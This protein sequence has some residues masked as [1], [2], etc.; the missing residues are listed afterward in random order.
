MSITTWADLKAA[1]VSRKIGVI[2]IV[3]KE[4]LD[5]IWTDQGEFSANTQLLDSCDVADWNDQA[6]ASPEIVNTVNKKQ[7]AASLD[8]GKSGIGN[9]RATYQK[10]AGSTFDGTGADFRVWVYVYDK[11]ELRSEALAGPVGAKSLH[12]SIGQDFGNIYFREYGP[13]ELKDVVNDGSDGWNLL[14]GPLSGFLTFGS[15]NITILDSMSL[16]FETTFATETI[17][18]GNIKMDYWRLLQDPVNVY[19]TP[20]DTYHGSDIQDVEKGGTAM[21]RAA[22]VTTLQSTPLDEFFYDIG[23]ELLY[24]NIDIDNTPYDFKYVVNHLMYFSNDATFRLDI[25]T[26]IA[27]IRP[28]PAVDKIPKVKHTNKGT[29]FGL[30]LISDASFEINNL[31]GL[32]D[33]WYNRLEWTDADCD[34]YLGGE[35]LPWSEYQIIYAGRVARGKGKMS[36]SWSRDALKIK[37]Q[38][39]RAR[40]MGKFIT[41]NR[42][43]IPEGDRYTL[44]VDR[45]N[46]GKPAP[47]MYGRLAYRIPAI[48]QNRSYTLGSAISAIAIANLE[49]VGP[50]TG[51]ADQAVAYIGSEQIG[52][53]GVSGNFLLALSRGANDTTA[54]AHEAGTPVT[55]TVATT[56]PPGATNF[57][58]YDPPDGVP[59]AAASILDVYFEDIVHTNANSFINA[60]GFLEFRDGFNV[61]G[62]SFEDGQKL[63]IDVEN[64]GGDDYGSILKSLLNDLGI[65]DA[66]LDTSSFTDLDGKIFNSTPGL[67]FDWNDKTSE[68]I[69][70]ILQSAQAWFIIDADGKISVRHFSPV[71][72]ASELIDLGESEIQP[73]WAQR[74]DSKRIRT[75]IS[76]LYK[77][78]YALS[79]DKEWTSLTGANQFEGIIPP[80]EK[81]LELETAEYN[82]LYATELRDHLMALTLFKQERVEFGALPLENIDLRPGDRIRVNLDRPWGS[83]FRS[84]EIE[85]VEINIDKG[86]VDI[87]LDAHNIYGLDDRVGGWAPD[88]ANNWANATADEK[89]ENGFWADDNG[90]IDPTD[91]DTRNRKVWY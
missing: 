21:N 71:V 65:L 62:Q 72:D 37:I 54:Q 52:Y 35:D 82:D 16:F 41:N 7:G 63:S 51:I 68:A 77:R 14:G 34:I 73:E 83:V 60:A 64:T 69:Q 28:D 19:S 88:G 80:E 10:V 50:I 76:V 29:V 49:L 79:G 59:A 47:K 12:I 81:E 1:P 24:I 87:A 33:E 46:V 36:V 13:N 48:A 78:K 3:P 9:V 53:I 8:L 18:S 6:A 56:T 90:F 86:G 38:D 31:N 20:L 32:L 40:I 11:T 55:V 44:G 91:G 15:P 67:F 5:D 61:T 42:D 58:V 70:M 26:A 75:N 39:K 85:E 30:S 27:T 43:P 23:N 22:S 57:S 17:A 45:L 25:P 2:K 66:D 4:L 74:W 84:Y 89:I